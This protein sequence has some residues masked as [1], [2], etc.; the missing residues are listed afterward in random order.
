M[1]QDKPLVPG[2]AP[3]NTAQPQGSGYMAGNTNQPTS[4]NVR[5]RPPRPQMVQAMRELVALGSDN[6]R[7]PEAVLPDF[8]R[9]LYNPRT[10]TFDRALW[11][12]T[13]G[14]MRRG[15]DITD[16]AGHVIRVCPPMTGTV[17]T[18]LG[19][20]KDQT[21][22]IQ[23]SINQIANDAALQGK[24]LAILEERRLSQGLANHQV[25]IAGDVVAAW[26]SILE[27]YGIIPKQSTVSKTTLSA[28][29]LLSDDGDAL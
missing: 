1:S 12:N 8:L 23:P 25:D 6:P 10:D 19:P 2:Q 24:R 22:H 27:D 21:G 13:V 18:R 5:K 16:A 7:M 9:Q 26:R 17:R 15:L 20:S 3:V 29:S 28:D 14:N 11:L 4:P